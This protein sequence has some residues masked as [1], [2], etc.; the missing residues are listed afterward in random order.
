M[1]SGPPRKPE[2]AVVRVEFK[3][4]SDK[5][6]RANALKPAMGNL[7]LSAAWLTIHFERA[8][9]SEKKRQIL[10]IRWN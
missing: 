3:L 6:L 2:N 5:A 8:S 7:K 1:A 4:P 9:P 10:H